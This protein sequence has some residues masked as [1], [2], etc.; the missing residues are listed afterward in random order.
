MATCSAVNEHDHALGL[1]NLRAVPYDV[2]KHDADNV[3]ALLLRRRHVDVKPF[4]RNCVT[5]L[6]EEARGHDDNLVCAALG[7]DDAV[8]RAERCAITD[9]LDEVEHPEEFHVETED[10][11]EDEDDCDPTE[12]IAEDEDELLG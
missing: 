1:L 2:G 7:V 6:I 3:L 4:C 9:K 12:F 11:D 10:L 5:S 8:S